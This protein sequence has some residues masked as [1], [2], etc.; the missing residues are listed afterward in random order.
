VQLLALPAG[1]GTACAVD[2]AAGFFLASLTAVTVYQGVVALQ[3]ALALH[4]PRY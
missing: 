2:G 1:W 3:V 4:P